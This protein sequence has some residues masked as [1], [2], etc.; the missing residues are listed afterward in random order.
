M[1]SS[2]NNILLPNDGS[3]IEIS[4]PSIEFLGNENLKSMVESTQRSIYKEGNSPYM[5]KPPSIK[6]NKIAETDTKEHDKNINDDYG[7]YF[8]IIKVGIFSMK[9]VKKT[10]FKLSDIKVS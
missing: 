1:L 2:Q 10:E 7:I 6:V 5:K 9:D 4:N 8:I 3:S